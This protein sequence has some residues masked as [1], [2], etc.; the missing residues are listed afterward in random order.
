MDILAPIFA[1]LGCVAGIVCAL[2]ISFMV[3]VSPPGQTTANKPNVA[4]AAS[5][6][7]VTTIAQAKA[8]PKADRHDTHVASAA[9]DAAAPP[10][11]TVAFSARHRAQ[12]SRAQYYRRLVEE[13]RL[14]RLAYQQNPEFEARF[15]GY[16][17]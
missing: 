12:I 1:Y 13:Q 3:Y 15:L 11:P 14:K 7:K 4:T 16:A 9:G 6:L 2:A 5:P 17:D 8:A 10:P